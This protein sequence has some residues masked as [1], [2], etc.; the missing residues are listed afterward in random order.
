MAIKANPNSVSARDEAEK[1]AASLPDLLVEADRI[2]MTITQGL[3]GRRRAGIG[4]TFWQY[5][6]YNE[7]DTASAID[8]R[9]SARAQH[10][11]VR[12]N[13]W[14][15]ANTVYLWVDLTASM[16]FR[17]HIADVTKR[18]RAL[19]IT[20]AL[21]NL[22]IGAGERV[23]VLGSGLTPSPHRTTT[24]KI[25]N[26]LVTDGLEQAKTNDG[27]PPLQQVSRFSNI[28]LIGDFL[29]HADDV[30]ERLI[31][32]AG[33][34]ITGHLLQ[35]LDPAEET[36]PYEGRKEFT[37]VA[38]P[39]KLTIG[40]VE[41]LRSAYQKKFSDHRQEIAALARRIGWSFNVHHTDAS[42]HRA[43]LSL[44]SM[45]SNNL[46]IAGYSNPLHYTSPDR[47]A[48]A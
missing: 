19:V 33:D 39:L 32:L 42:P 31:K 15:A 37:E 4:E 45:M 8:W 11:Y 6:R 35:V 38:G 17:S 30:S 14:E 26:W 3:H 24:R 16:G 36:L 9:R 48:E 28:V 18:A 34:N 46:G 23:S 20:L 41:G 21:S 43:L 47:W 7:S 22:L 40:R 10:T 44:Y 25:G 12:E 27:L 5:R 2:A 1:L 29:A 13:E